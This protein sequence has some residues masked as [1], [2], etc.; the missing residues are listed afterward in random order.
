[1][2]IFIDYLYGTLVNPK[3]TLVLLAAR[4]NFGMGAAAFLIVTF[5]SSL[6][7]LMGEDLGEVAEGI[8]FGAA[9]PAIFLIT[10]LVTVIMWLVGLGV[11]HLLAELLGGEGSIKSLIAT[12][13]FAQLPAIFIVPFAFLSIFIGDWLTI[14]ASLLLGI[15][16]VI[17]SVLAVKFSYNLSTGRSILAVILPAVIGVAIIIIIAILI[18]FAIWPTISQMMGSLV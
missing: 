9:L 10:F 11:L 12:Q 5:F 3:K 7:A 17:L 16:T 13:G 4:Q 15:W 8:D 6:A 1:M 2:N 18:I 14:T